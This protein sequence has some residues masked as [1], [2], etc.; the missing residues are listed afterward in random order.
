MNLLATLI[1]EMRSHNAQQTVDELHRVIDGLLPVPRSVVA[2]ELCQ[3]FTQDVTVLQ[4]AV[5]GDVDRQDVENLR[6]AALETAT[7][8]ADMARKAA[9]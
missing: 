4:M 2:Q 3:R 1:T 5:I 9:H 7:S 8:V 6:A